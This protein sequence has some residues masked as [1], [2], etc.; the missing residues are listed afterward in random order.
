MELGQ[1]YAGSTAIV[2]DGTTLPEPTRDPELYYEPH[3]TPG[4]RLPHCWVG[5][6][7][8][9]VSTHDLA[10]YSQFTLFTGKTGR[11]W[12]EAAEQVAAQLGV[13]LKAVVIGPGE[14]VQDLYFDWMKLREVAEDGAVL[15]RPDTHV[16]WRS[17][18]L[19]DDPAGTLAEV[20]TTVLH[21]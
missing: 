3:T 18:N 12:A 6:S 20:M 15:V 19:V 21:R 5:D 2:G 17:E 1:N 9:K 10:K 16:A 8:S 14:K 4:V 11:A 13:P 7:R